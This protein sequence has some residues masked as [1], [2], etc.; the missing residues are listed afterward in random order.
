MMSQGSLA[1]SSAILLLPA[2]LFVSGAGSIITYIII[3]VANR[4]EPDPTGKR[5]ATV[6]FFGGAFLTLW[7]ALIGLVITLAALINLIGSHPQF[8]G[9]PGPGLVNPTIRNVSVGLLIF[10]I[11]GAAHFLHV[12]RGLEL[13]ASDSDEASPAKRVARSYVNVV[14]FL[15]VLVFVIATFVFFFLILGLIAPGVYEAGP[16]MSTFR[17]LLDA[18]MVLGIATLVFRR[19]QRFE[20]THLR[21][22]TKSGGVVIETPNVPAE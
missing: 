18:F 2:L 17:A 13:A 15:S 14:S 8:G 16:R 1:I 9:Y 5:P 12:R 20:P 6:Y 22:F 21:L 11:A 19:H 7:I 3:V 4:A 10:L